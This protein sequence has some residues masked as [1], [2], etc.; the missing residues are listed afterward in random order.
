MA[1]G[2]PVLRMCA[3]RS[4][5]ALEFVTSTVL[6]EGVEDAKQY[7]VASDARPKGVAGARERIK[8]QQRHPKSI[9]SCLPPPLMTY[10]DVLAHARDFLGRA[11]MSSVSSGS[12]DRTCDLEDMSLPSCHCSIPLSEGEIEALPLIA[13]LTSC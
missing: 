12:R 10:L 6:V 5:V 1:D 11:S 3:P 2:V 8:P 4:T 9:Q 13:F 7:D